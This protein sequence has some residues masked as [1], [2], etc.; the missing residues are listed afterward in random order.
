MRGRL[1][2][3]FTYLLLALSGS[4]VGGEGTFPPLRTHYDVLRVPRT[5]GLDE[6][7]SAHKLLSLEYHP[8]KKGRDREES[9]K[10]MKRINR[11]YQ[12]LSNER[13]KSQYDA[14]LH[15]VDADHD[16][17]SPKSAPALALPQ[18]DGMGDPNSQVPSKQGGRGG[19]GGGLMGLGGSLAEPLMDFALGISDLFGP[20]LSPRDLLQGGPGASSRAARRRRSRRDNRRKQRG[21]TGMSDRGGLDAASPSSASSAD[22][23][24]EFLFGDQLGELT[25]DSSDSGGG[26]GG[27]GVPGSPGG[28][29]R[30]FGRSTMTSVRQENGHKIAETREQRSDGSSVTRIERTAPDGSRTLLIRERKTRDGPE[31]VTERRFDKAG[32]LLHSSEGTVVA[33]DSETETRDSH[34]GQG[35]EM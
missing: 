23:L 15:L 21:D 32:R 31:K 34:N 28:V 26:Q 18:F 9:E 2:G 35:G 22:S 4:T 1:L 12:I 3:A 30:S 17:E 13:L 11:A 16:P 25:R 27:R 24:A 14:L 33:L 7:K 8:L 5:A 19:S 29:F 20:V 10:A 6:I